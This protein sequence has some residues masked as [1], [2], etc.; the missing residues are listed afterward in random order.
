MEG[1]GAAAGEAYAWA[2]ENPDKVSCIY[3][4]WS[5]RIR[6]FRPATGA[7]ARSVTIR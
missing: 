6:S 1:A 5:L 3:G 4:G 7:D 2:I